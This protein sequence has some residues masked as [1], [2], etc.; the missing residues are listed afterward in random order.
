[1]WAFFTF[2]VQ[3]KQINSSLSVYTQQWDKRDKYS[4]FQKELYN[5]TPNVTVILLL[6]TVQDASKCKRFP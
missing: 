4:M 2:S 5:S 3:N 6:T 1:M